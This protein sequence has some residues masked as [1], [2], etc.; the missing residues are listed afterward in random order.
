[1][2]S[3][4]VGS[5]APWYWPLY[6]LNLAKVRSGMRRFMKVNAETAAASQTRLLAALRRLDEA[7]L[8]GRF[9][10]GGVFTRADLSAAA[11]TGPMTRPPSYGLDW[12]MGYPPALEDFIAQER[13]RPWFQWAE[14]LYRDYRKPDG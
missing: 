5:G 14:G 10:V 13:E 9:L 1:M 3:R 4:K 8:D 6:R 7:L 11:L 12:S 2:L